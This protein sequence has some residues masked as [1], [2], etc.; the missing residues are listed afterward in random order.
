MKQ[1]K[2]LLF[3]SGYWSRRK[4]AND[5]GHDVSPKVEHDKKEVKDSKENALPETSGYVSFTEAIDAHDRS[6]VKV[7]GDPTPSSSSSPGTN[8]GRTPVAL[9]S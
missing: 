9:F 8:P 4:K 3:E 1:A 2:T 6:I 7:K 5:E